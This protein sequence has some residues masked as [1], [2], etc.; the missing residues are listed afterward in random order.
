MKLLT[1]LTLVTLNCACILTAKADSLQHDQLPQ[2]N[3]LVKAGNKFVTLLGTQVAVGD[4]APDFKVVNE[5][6]APIKL[7]DFV[8]KTVLISVVPSL[9]TGVCSLQTKRF[10][11]E[12]ASL[13]ENIAIL[14]VSNDLPFAQKRFCKS[15]NIDKVK[16]LSDAVWRDFGSKYGL[17]IKDM[18]L[19]TRAIF[20]IDQQGIIAYKELVANISEHPDYDTALAT[21]K[22]LHPKE[23]TEILATEA[24][25]ADTAAEPA[26]ASDE[27]KKQ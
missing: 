9:D 25:E 22:A 7:T 6:F 19:L 3:N 21:L 24:Q 18:G 13:P 12:V 4:A 23:L 10:N 8:N 5:H 2:T 26:Q 17:L 27:I 14:T 1:L 16:V 11:E 15:E 20:I